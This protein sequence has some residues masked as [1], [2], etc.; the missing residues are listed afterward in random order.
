MKSLPA[1]QKGKWVLG[2]QF[3]DQKAQNLSMKSKLFVKFQSDFF[4]MIFDGIVEEKIRGGYVGI[5]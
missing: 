1:T 4:C 2:K 5:G 3:V